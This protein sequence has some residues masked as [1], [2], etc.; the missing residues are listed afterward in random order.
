MGRRD[1]R[2]SDGSGCRPAGCG[3]DHRHQCL[4]EAAAG[5]GGDPDGP[6]LWLIKPRPTLEVLWGPA[7]RIEQVVVTPP[8]K[9]WETMHALELVYRDAYFSQLVDRYQAKWQEYAKLARD[10]RESFIASGMAGERSGA[11][12]R[13]RRAVHR[14]PGRRAA[15]RSTRAW[16]G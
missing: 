8:L 1:D 9:R 12:G 7:L 10:A 3:A 11:P 13:S 4:D 5:A 16:P 6:E 2:R 14:R 15:E